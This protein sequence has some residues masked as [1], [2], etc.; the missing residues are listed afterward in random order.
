MRTRPEWNVR[1]IMAI[2]THSGVSEKICSTCRQ[3]KPLADFPTDRTHGASQGHRHCRCRQCHRD[4]ARTR[5]LTRA[6]SAS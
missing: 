5:R 3:W 1:T 2:K 4:A 6:T